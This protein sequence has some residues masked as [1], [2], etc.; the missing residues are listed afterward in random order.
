MKKIIISLFLIVCCN[1]QTFSQNKFNLPV[2]VIL[3]DDSVPA[4]AG[5][6]LTTKLKSIL[7]KNGYMASDGV[8]RFVL[9]A[10]ISIGTKDILPTNPPRISQKMDV[11]FF[12]GDVID[13][14][15]YE[16]CTVEAKGIGVNENKAF[17][18]SFQSISSQN[19]ELAEMLT[20]ARTSISEYYRNTYK[21]V[22]KKADALVRNKEY[23]AAI[24]ELTS[25]PEVDATITAE[26]QNAVIA[27]YQQ[28][29]DDE[30]RPLLREAKS[31]WMAEK[32]HDAGKKASELL[33]RISP[34]SS[35]VGEADALLGEIDKKLRA[36]E[37]AVAA[38]KKEETE[39]QRK[40]EEEQIEYQREREEDD[41]AYDRQKEQRD[42]EFTREKH[43][44]E[45]AYRNSLLA[46][47]REV[48]LAYAKNQPKTI[49]K[50]IIRSW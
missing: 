17:I 33:A 37:A 45:Q 49:T 25:I 41:I 32:N 16:S 43:R 46:A 47:S 40:R 3:A 30:A 22:L 8:Q 44:D 35:V 28:K 11:T 36:D 1:W 12:I 15:I 6:V 48:S 10:K 5:N 26:C 27:V 13:N 24:Y 4:E 39:Y 14:R 9:T 18:S 7:T 29:I 31:I 23:D 20:V 19:K 2:A 42:F 21:M 38:R 50:N 34:M